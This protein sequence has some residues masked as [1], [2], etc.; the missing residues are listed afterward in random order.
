MEAAPGTNGPTGTRETWFSV[1]SEGTVGSEGLKEMLAR[2]R[3]AQ[4][5]ATARWTQGLQRQARARAPLSLRQERSGERG[6]ILGNH[7]T[8]P[9]VVASSGVCEQNASDRLTRLRENSR[10]E[11]FQGRWPVSGKLENPRV[12]GCCWPDPTD[13]VCTS[14]K[15]N[16]ATSVRGPCGGPAE[17]SIPNLST[18]VLPARRDSHAHAA[19]TRAMRHTLRPQS[20]I[21]STPT[22]GPRGVPIRRPHEVR[23]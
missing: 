5:Q 8:S 21:R 14:T 15:H 3:P 13:R 12:S 11:Q 16:L 23:S 2:L 4:Q 17:L 22:G 6:P 18:P 20:R 9:G 7:R 1:R 19:R 10:S